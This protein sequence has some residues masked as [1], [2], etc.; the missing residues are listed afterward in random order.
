MGAHI[1]RALGPTQ[2]PLYPMGLL[3]CS[4]RAAGVEK[5]PQVLPASLT[6]ETRSPP[7]RGVFW[8]PTVVPTASSTNS[9]IVSRDRPRLAQP[10]V[11]RDR[12]DD[13]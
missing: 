11:A 1:A 7:D 6:A 4:D 2:V 12:V 8:M 5:R 10:E 3:P 13:G 9:D